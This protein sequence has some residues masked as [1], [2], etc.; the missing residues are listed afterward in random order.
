MDEASTP[1]VGDVT[2]LDKTEKVNSNGIIKLDGVQLAALA[3]T[4]TGG[5]DKAFV[6]QWNPIRNTYEFVAN[7]AV[8]MFFSFS[9]IFNFLDI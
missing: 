8:D 4:N 2:S 6:T 1:N 9:V 5:T 3:P 7:T